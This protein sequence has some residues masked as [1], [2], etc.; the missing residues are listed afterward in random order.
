[1]RYLL[2]TLVAV[3]TMLGV[4]SASPSLDAAAFRSVGPAVSGGRLGAVAG[5]D[6]DPALYYVGAAG[7][8][9]WKTTNA[10]ASWS[11]VFDGQA[12]SSIGAIAIDPQDE[13]TVWVGTG[14]ANPRNDVSQGDGLYRT[15]DGGK[16]WSHVLPLRDALISAIAVDPRDGKNVTV[17]V[18]GDPFADNV[19]RGIYR[20][21]D[22]GATWSKVLYRGPSSGASDLVRSPKHPDVLFAGLWQFRR[23]GWSLDSGGPSDGLYRSTDNGATWNK[24]AGHGLPTDTLGR[25]GVAVGTSDA[26]RVY[27]LIQSKQGLLWR[28]D[29]GGTSWRLA[30]ADPL[31]DE[32]PFYFNHVFVDPTNAD[33][34]WTASVHLTESKDGGATFKPVGRDL[35]GD[36]HAM[37]IS[38]D[39]RRIIE[40]NDGGV[41]FSNDG[42][43]TWEWRTDLPIS[44]LYHVGYS[45]GRSYSVCVSL[46]DNGTYCAPSDPLD[47]GGV[48]AARWL[49]VGSGDGAW[50]T[51]DP[52][53]SSLIWETDAGN[54]FAGDVNIHDLRT[55]ETRSIA[56]YSTDQNVVDPKALRYRFNWE[57]PIAFDPFDGHVAFVGADV[58]FTTRDRG[59]HW[60]ALSG[61]LT[62]NDRA[63]QSVGGGV[64]LDGT[65]AETSDTILAIEPS[66]KTRGQ[67]WV[68]TDD[69][70]IR[71]TRDGGKHWSDVT[72]AFARAHP[73]GRFAA[74]SA[75]P[76]SAG[77]AYAIYDRHMVGDRAPYA[78]ATSDFGRHWESIAAGLPAG[79]E[80]RT[81]LVDPHEPDLLYVGLENGLYASWDRG[82]HWRAIGSGLPPA[83][84]RDVRV[85]PDANDLLVATHGRGLYILD[86]ATPLQGLSAARARGAQLFP[87]RPATLWQRQSYW[88]TPYDGAGPPAG[89]IVTFYQKTASRTPPT[90][91]VVDASGRVVRHIGSHVDH[92]KT[93]RDIAN[94]AGLDRFAWD[95]SEDA[96]VPWRYAPVWNRGFGRGQQVVPGHYVVRVSFAGKTFSQ[97]VAVSA[98]PRTHYTPSEAVARRDALRALGADFSRVDVALDA[99]S[100]VVV[101]A[102]LRAK[103]LRAA[104]DE[105][106]ALAVE[107]AG[108]QA[109]DLIASITSNP[110]NDQDNDFLRDMLRE[111]LQTEIFT[112]D[113]SFAPPSAEQRR[114]TAVL[115]ALTGDRI[116]RYR[117][118]SNATLRVAEAALAKAHLPSLVTATTRPTVTGQGQGGDRR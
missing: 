15:R 76:S 10:G 8:G 116:A 50:A 13:R 52:L 111:R 118:F 89:A 62:R 7:G 80:A 60:R 96:P 86:D 95:L 103:A 70:L 35:H 21:V 98:D 72:P 58:L 63:H 2:A 53:D 44:Q 47:D 85:V 59:Y 5:T 64:T 14:E 66:R 106:G 45:R 83:S 81:I 108:T 107:A 114:E 115:H 104:G 99:L 37:W 101:E 105:P 26:T 4:A 48:N 97:P 113:G 79:L 75:S 34:V 54:N 9:V 40:G 67:I 100:T 56:P 73:W 68:G 39:G 93:V 51:Y 12:Q 28:S 74:I 102:P 22:G 94:V 33:R 19:D 30:T 65:G 112:Y 90:A 49:G 32:R 91:V 20:T 42:G 69:G 1:V 24:L 55:G 29:D 25:I 57:V 23:T 87:I 84:I 11:P 117:A 92:G 110:A 71:L 61:D 18:L 16:T 77:T 17:A 38:A 43:T 46:Q 78:F 27:A 31:I 41:A 82:A 88:S 109:Q 36:H 6:A 3:A